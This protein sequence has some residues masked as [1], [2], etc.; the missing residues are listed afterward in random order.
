MDQDFFGGLDKPQQ[1]SDK[2][3]PNIAFLLGPKNTQTPAR[4]KIKG[5]DGQ[6]AEELKWAKLVNDEGV[7]K[8]DNRGKL[9][10]HLE[11]LLTGLRRRYI[12]GNPQSFP[13]NFELAKLTKVIFALA[14]IE[15]VKKSDFGDL[16]GAIKRIENRF[17]KVSLLGFATELTDRLCRVP[18]S[19]VT[20]LRQAADRNDGDK[21]VLAAIEKFLKGEPP[22]SHSI[23]W[24]NWYLEIKQ[25]KFPT[26][27]VMSKGDANLMSATDASEGRKLLAYLLLMDLR[28]QQFEWVATYGKATEAS[29][30]WIYLLQRPED[31]TKLTKVYWGRA[32]APEKLKESLAVLGNRGRRNRSYRKSQK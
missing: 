30:K 4:I 13:T 26:S 9:K 6:L 8:S 11:S 27:A 23:P 15:G 19:P 32:L 18:P 20:V 22:A 10:E 7:L 17:S 12:E 31:F 2:K 16:R 3:K 24:E 14:R 1:V 28:R 21:A 29:L 5:D 25:L